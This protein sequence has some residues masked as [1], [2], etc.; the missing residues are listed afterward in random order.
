MKLKSLVGP[1]L[2]EIRHFTVHFYKRPV[3]D[4]TRPDITK[5]SEA[6]SGNKAISNSVYVLCGGNRVKMEKMYHDYEII[7][8]NPRSVAKIEPEVKPRPK[9]LTQGSLF[10][11]SLEW[12]KA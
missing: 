12:F 10:D 1:I 2:E 6:A 7:I 5:Y 9:P 3:G 8:D 11:N 4:K